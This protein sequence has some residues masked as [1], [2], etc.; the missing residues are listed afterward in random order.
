MSSSFVTGVIKINTVS[1]TGP[2]NV[3]ADPTTNTTN[4]FSFSWQPPAVYGGSVSN[5]TYCYTVNTL[6][7]A[8]T[9]SF[10]AAG[11]TSVPSAAYATQPGDNTF[12]VVAKDEA[13]NINYATYGQ[14]IFTANTSAP[15][16][17]LS[18]D[19]ADISVK[20]TSSWRL[21]LSWDPPT[22]VGAGVSSYRVY[23]STNDVTYTNVASTSGSSYVDSGL[24][25]VE[26][27][28]K[29]RACDSANNC[30][31]Y[32]PVVTATPTGKF[33]TPAEVVSVPK[34]NEISTRKATINW[35]TD[36]NSDSRI[37]YGLSA[38]E[39]FSTEA[40]ISAQTTDHEV[41]LNNLTAGTTY[42]FKARWTD[43]DGNIGTSGEYSFTTSPAPVVKEVVSAP[44]LTT[45]GINFTSKDASKVKIYYGK[46]EGFGG[47]AELN[48]SLSESSYSI[49]IDGLD[50]GSKYF[51]KINTFDSDSN[52][53]EGNVYSFTTP[54]RPRISNVRFQP[55]ENQPSSTQKVSW[56]TNVAANSE[57]SY[58]VG[59]LA[60]TTSDNKLGTLHEVTISGL[61]DDSTY[62]LV[63]R[64][65]DENGNLAQ[66][67]IQIFKTALD[68]RPPT[69]SEVVVEVSIRGTGTEARGQIVVSWKTDEPATS[70]VAYGEGSAGLLS[71][72]TNE[73]TKLS[74]DHVIVIS[75]LSTSRVYHLE[76]RSYDKARNLVA[77]EQQIA[78]IGRASENVLSI[79]FN[80]LQN[81]FGVSA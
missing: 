34:V 25:P 38:G 63:A 74:T 43:V 69:V 11:V 22:D 40:A 15:G 27:F 71:S 76:P 20:S 39:Y 37:Q 72:V 31:A 17:P 61:S 44:T 19:I 70:Q 50:D 58:G 42:Y 59:N 2:L 60:K 9:C 68:T 33:T 35:S 49:S 56:T 57:V 41:A 45:A 8:N 32:T 46:S 73:D 80:A 10:T 48:T 62:Q 67:D 13:G 18:I 3:T 24:Q 79:I 51:Y 14:A 66:S 54:A 64:S 55:V 47:T 81:I 6:P 23:R 75:D 78:I 30:G 52:E 28:Y 7:S 29:V 53:Y 77:G 26:Y 36:R 4:S 21:A 65:R 5:L 16:I 12:Y 1:P